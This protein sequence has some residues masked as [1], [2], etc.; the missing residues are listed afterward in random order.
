L[1]GEEHGYKTR[2]AQAMLDSMSGSGAFLTLDPGSQTN[3]F[4]SLMKKFWVKS[5]I[6]LSFLAKKIFLSVQKLKFFLIF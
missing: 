4:D 6:I 2:G 1:C 5:T 3:I